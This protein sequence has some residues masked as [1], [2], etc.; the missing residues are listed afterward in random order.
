MALENIYAFKLS[1]KNSLTV[2]HCFKKFISSEVLSFSFTTSSSDANS[3][4]ITSLNG[5]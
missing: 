1:S 4:A 5:H 3:E 2:S